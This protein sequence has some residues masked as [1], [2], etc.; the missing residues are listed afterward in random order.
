MYKGP[1]PY[2]KKTGGQSRNETFRGIQ[3]LPRNRYNATSQDLKLPCDNCS[4]SS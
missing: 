1:W 4:E 2:F 3:Q